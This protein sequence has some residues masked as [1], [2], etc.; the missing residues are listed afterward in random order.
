MRFHGIAALGIVQSDIGL[1]F[2]SM[3]VHQWV[4]EKGGKVVHGAVIHPQSQG[5]IEQVHW[6]CS[7]IKK[8]AKTRQTAV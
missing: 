1:E 8:T 6:A 7:E 2:R 3:A 5:A 4:A